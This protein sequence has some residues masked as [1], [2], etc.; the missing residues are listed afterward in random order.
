MG[1]KYS[2]DYY[3]GDIAFFIALL[4][5]FI[6]LVHSARGCVETVGKTKSDCCCECIETTN[7]TK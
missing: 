3:L 6:Y 2:K 4:L 1:N 7:L 5:A